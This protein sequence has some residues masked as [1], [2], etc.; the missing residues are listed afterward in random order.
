MPSSPVKTKDRQD[1]GKPGSVVPRKA[2][3]TR[4]CI[5]AEGPKIAFIP[6]EGCAWRNLL[7]G[8]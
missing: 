2:A 1:A 4:V 5:L 6:I 8:V 3:L 7:I